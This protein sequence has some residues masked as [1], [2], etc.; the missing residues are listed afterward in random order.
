MS[1]LLV[2]A[3]TAA[4]SLAGVLPGT[5]AMVGSIVVALLLVA[6]FVAYERRSE[7]HGDYDSWRQDHLE[8]NKHSSTAVLLHSRNGPTA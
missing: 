6:V 5:L 7:L 2:T 3:A 4:V 1:L 8:P